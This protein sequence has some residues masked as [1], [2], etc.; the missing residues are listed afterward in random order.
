M[1]SRISAQDTWITVI[2]VTIPKSKFA[3]FNLRKFTAYL[4]GNDPNGAGCHVGHAN[5]LGEKQKWEALET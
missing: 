5:R 2:M 1:A 3:V 4:H